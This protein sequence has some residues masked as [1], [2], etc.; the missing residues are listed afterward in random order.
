MEIRMTA[1]GEPTPKGRPK[2]AMRGNFPTVYTPKATRQAED[3]LLQQ[4]IKHKPEKP[5]EGAIIMTIRF[6]K[7][8][9]KS[10][11]KRITGWTKKPDLD[12]MTKLVLDAMNKVFYHDDAQIVEITSSKQYDEVPRTEIVLC[13]LGVDNES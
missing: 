6:Y 10:Y 13:K 12:N 8:K 4:I 1:Y 7:T 5:I 11:P 9:P 2:I 3:T